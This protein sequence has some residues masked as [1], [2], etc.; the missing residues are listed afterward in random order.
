MFEKVI[1]K[2]KRS[3]GLAT[4]IPSG[5]GM[6]IP[7]SG[8]GGGGEYGAEITDDLRTF[9]IT[10]EPVAYR[11]VFTVA[12]DIF[13]NWFE[14]KLEGDE[15]G[16]K[17]KV[18][19]KQIQTELTRLRAKEEFSRMSVFERAYGWAIIVLGYE[20]SEESLVKPVKNANVLREIKAYG[21][22][23]VMRVDEVKDTS[24][25]R[26]GLPEI[27]NI[28][29]PGIA[30][31]LKV[32]YTRVIHFSTRLINHDWKGRSTL[33]PIWDDLTTLRNIR[34]GMGQTMYRYGSGFPDITFNNAEQSDIQD[35][36]DAGG[37][38]NW[39]SR[40]GFVHNEDQIFEFKGPEGHALNPMN[41]YLPIM[42]NISCGSGIPLAILRG[43]QAGA[44]TGSEVNQQ[45]YYGL[46]SDEQ[47]AYESGIREL[48]NIIQS[49]KKS[50]KMTTSD[51]ETTKQDFNFEWQGGFELDE[52]KKAEIE[53]LEMQALQIKANFLTRNEIRALID[54]NLGSLTPEQ[55]G[56]EVLGKQGFGN[57]QFDYHVREIPKNRPN[58]NRS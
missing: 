58:T 24:D 39:N 9:A 31:Y 48:I 52:K 3:V 17:S 8:T 46:V 38:D 2:I 50:D 4:A 29:R 13:D 25:P 11:V 57:E 14:L 5:S 40:T 30:A 34:W 12:H 26:Y 41:F 56:E 43:V 33:D 23:Q 1:Q 45:E 27:Y 49:L 54:P 44:L 55:G 28:K 19:D 7:R 53:Q 16:E 37:L 36:I 42:E 15:K 20:D 21:P 6:L 10:R 47:S 35:W 51:Q 22:T 32:H 18:F